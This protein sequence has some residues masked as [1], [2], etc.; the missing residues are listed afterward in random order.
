MSFF[1]L[2]ILKKFLV[3]ASINKQTNINMTLSR[4]NA[5][6]YLEFDSAI[7]LTYCQYVY[8]ES[9]CSM[10]KYISSIIVAMGKQTLDHS[11][12]TDDNK[13]FN[14]HRKVVR[15]SFNK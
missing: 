4:K 8:A 14:S 7:L 15:Q 13:P 5:N 12:E 9:V 6:R 2:K 10:T 11:I 3:L 1:L